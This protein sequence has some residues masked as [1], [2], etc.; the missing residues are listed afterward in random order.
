M[1]IIKN[2]VL[3]FKTNLNNKPAMSLK[4]FNDIKKLVINIPMTT[5]DEPL[6]NPNEIANEIINKI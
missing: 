4:E 6:C 5:I 1:L 2:N 3:F